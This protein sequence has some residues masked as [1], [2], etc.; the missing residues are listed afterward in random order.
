METFTE[1]IVQIRRH[2]KRS[3]IVEFVDDLFDID[4]AGCYGAAAKMNRIRVYYCFSTKMDDWLH[5]W[6]ERKNKNP[7]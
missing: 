2:G 3:L 5:G 6:C 1:K 7:F 4:H